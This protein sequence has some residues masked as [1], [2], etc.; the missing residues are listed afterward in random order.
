MESQETAVVVGHS[1]LVALD[2][3]MATSLDLQAEIPHYLYDADDT[4]LE[5]DAHTCAAAAAAA[6]ELDTV[7]HM[8]T[9][10]SFQDYKPVEVDAAVFVSGW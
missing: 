10:L 1:V 3:S 7:V 5:D 9:A 2:D 6:V 8:E 4:L